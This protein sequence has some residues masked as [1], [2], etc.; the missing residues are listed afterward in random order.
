MER[1]WSWVT[2][3]NKRLLSHHK[4]RRVGGGYTVKEYNIREYLVILRDTF[5]WISIAL[6]KYNIQEEIPYGVFEDIASYL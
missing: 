1:D 5:F 3:E 4:V 2:L 6:E